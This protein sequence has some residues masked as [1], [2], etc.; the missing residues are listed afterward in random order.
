MRQSQLTYYA[1]LA[2]KA[3][4]AWDLGNRTDAKK[5]ASRPSYAFIVN[6]YNQIMERSDAIILANSLKGIKFEF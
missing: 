3:M 2:D 4:A 1:N 5:L 6:Y